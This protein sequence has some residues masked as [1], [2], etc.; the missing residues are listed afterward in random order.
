MDKLK[1]ITVKNPFDRHGRDLQV[2]DH[3]GETL[4]AIRDANFPTDVAVVVSLNGKA[5]TNTELA[6]TVP[7]PGDE[8]LFAPEIGD[9]DTMRMV[10]MIAVTVAAVA[11][12]GPGGFLINGGIWGSLAVMGT[13]MVGGYLVNSMLPPANPQLPAGSDLMNSQVYAWSPQTV[14]AQGIPIPR[15]YGTNKVYGNI[16]SAYQRTEGV[17][18]RLFILVALGMGPLD[19]V[20]DFRINDQPADDSVFPG[21]SVKALLGKLS[22]DSLPAFNETP[23][24]HSL[25]LKVVYGTPQTYT[26]AG[27]AYDFLEIDINF[28]YGV[29]NMSAD[30]QMIPYIVQYQVE[31]QAQGGTW[32][33]LSDCNNQ[34]WSTLPRYTSARW[35]AGYFIH[36][37]PFFGIDYGTGFD[38]FGNPSKFK[39]GTLWYEAVAGSANINDHVPGEIYSSPGNGSPDITWRWVDPVVNPSWAEILYCTTKNGWERTICN[40]RT[41]ITVTYRSPKL[42]HGTYNIRITN[43]T[44]DQTSAYYGDDLYLTSVREFSSD[45]YVYPR[46]AAVQVA[47]TATDKLSGSFKFSCMTNGQL[48]RVYNGTSWVIQVSISPAWVCYDILTQPVLYDQWAAAMRYESGQ[49]VIPLTLNNRLYECTTAGIS[50][51]TQPTWPTTIG[52]TVTDGTAVWTCRAGAAVDGVA[53]FDGIDPSRVDYL[54]FKAWADWC[55]TLVNGEKRITFNGAFDSDTSMWDAALQ[56]CKIG[57]AVLFQRGTTYTVAVDK[58]A[59]SSQF[60]SVG[61]IEKGSFQLSYLPM[62]DRASAVEVDYIDSENGYQRTTFTVYNNAIAGNPVP[63]SLQL[64]GTTK[65]KEAYRHALYWLYC[66]Q[67]ISRVVRFSADVDAIGCTLGDVIDVQH[68]APAWGFGGRVVSATSTSVTIDKTVTIAAG[69]TYSFLVRTQDNTI[70]TKIVTNVPGDYTVLNLSTPFSPTPAQYD[71]YAFGEQNL[72]T[73]AYRVTDISQD[74]KLK[75]AITAAEYNVNIQNCDSGTEMVPTPNYEPPVIPGVMPAPATGLI[76][77]Q[78]VYNQLDPAYVPKVNVTYAVDQDTSGLWQSGHV[79]YGID[80][81][82]GYTWVSAGY[83]YSRGAG[84]LIDLGST[85]ASGD[86]LHVMVVAVSTSGQEGLLQN[87]PQAPIVI[88]SSGT[89]P[90]PTGLALEIGGTTWNGRKFAF[91]WDAQN[92]LDAYNVTNEVVINVGGTDRLTVKTKDNRYEYVYGDGSAS[93]LDSYLIAANGA[94]TINVRRVSPIATSSPYITLAITQAAPA[95]PAN[96]VSV[97][98]IRG[99]Y[100]Q[101]DRSTETDFDK[102]KIRTKITSGGTW[103]AQTY[104]ADPNYTRTMSDA[105]RTTFGNTPDIY[106][107]VIAADIFGNASGAATTYQAA[108]A[109]ASDEVAMIAAGYN[110]LINSDFENGFDGW[111]PDADAGSVVVATS[112]KSGI[113]AAENTAGHYSIHYGSKYIPIQRD[114]VLMP[115][116]Y[117]KTKTAGTLGSCYA[118][119]TFYDSSKA[120]ISEF[121]FANAVVPGSSFTYYNGA[122]GPGQANDYPSNAVY[123]RPCF[124]LDAVPLWTA[125]DRVQ[126]IQGF[127]VREV[128][129]SAYIK[130]LAVIDEKIANC[131]VGKLISGSIISQSITL[132]I[133]EAAGDVKI[134]AGKT[135]FGDTAAGFILGMDDSDSNKAKFEIGDGTKYLKWDGSALLIRGSLNA[136][137]LTAGCIR[138]INVTAATH[139]TKGS[140]LTSALSGGESTINVKDTSDFP[141]SGNGWIIDTTND[142]DGFVWTGKTATTLTGCSGVLAHN[143]GATIIPQVKTCI[144]DSAVNEIRGYGDLGAGVEEILSLGIVP[145]SPDSFVSVFGSQ[146]SGNNKVAVRALSNSNTAIIGLTT[147]GLG[148]QLFSLNGY[149]A[150]VQCGSSGKSP[151]CLY[152]SSSA[153]APTHTADKGSLWVTSAGV[154]YINTDGSTTWAKVGAQ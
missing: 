69:K 68:D 77:T 115:E 109:L 125:G 80:R 105:E 135:D 112:P 98:L 140:Y 70:Q 136:D 137:D 45:K 133:T 1:L 94:C 37:S 57:R 52:N 82:S 102:Y 44:P 7:R 143:S 36:A 63:A 27:N 74:G 12:F 79:Y 138:G 48:M 59:T 132:A 120:Y 34:L 51:S 30:G 84:F 148:A 28:P 131:S 130:N 53:R 71:V 144:V 32:Y 8:V 66:N 54:Q 111:G 110:Q 123:Y 11:A 117:F 56:V 35:T 153:S 19:N 25:S 42:A 121:V 58:A 76:L 129:E 3:G 147:D 85:L 50:G 139:M 88:A 20:Y 86:T 152:P 142:R 89:L 78:T 64:F 13:V 4:L 122:I 49:Y 47:A 22:Q 10:L 43:M 41:P 154:L 15:I 151:L 5:L 21:I 90:T 103:S 14:Q 33:L 91:K 61:N 55:D 40:N 100:F 29:W 24:E 18:K 127:R 114:R 67:Y 126:Q 107:E 26:P 46:L 108:A 16:I 128:I 119:I 38:A 150:R 146:S 101:W 73:R 95:Q 6:L 65:A 81:G 149:G 17:D 116:C 93:A 124:L 145:G 134:Q 141:S 72:A 39:R 2:V 106:I 83:D 113:Y 104:Q 60:F 97:G 23:V 31:I 62:E 75:M 99:A 118:M 9:D 87:S 96:L 92:G